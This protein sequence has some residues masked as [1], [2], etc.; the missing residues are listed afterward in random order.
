MTG[1]KNILPG[2]IEKLLAVLVKLYKKENKNDLAEIIV[3]SQLDVVEEVDYDNW[4][5]GTWGHE[6]IFEIPEELYLKFFD[7]RA[8]YEQKITEDINKINTIDDEYVYTTKI[9]ILETDHGNWRKD[10]GLLLDNKILSE[11]NYHEILWQKNMYRMFLSHKVTYKKETAELKKKLNF[12]GIDCFVAHEDIEPTSEWQKEIEKALFSMDC[13][14]ALMTKDFP[15]SNWTDQEVGVA[16]GRQVPIICPRLGKDPY[17]FIGK[18]QGLSAGWD[19]LDIELVKLLL[20]KEPKYVDCYI[21]A[22]KKC[23]SFDNGNKYAKVLPVIEKL[24]N[25]QAMKLK[26]IYEENGE[27][28]GAFGFNGTKSRYYGAGLSYHLKRI[29]GR[30]FDIC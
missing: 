28:Q 3:N 24:T 29:T 26:S 2:K 27:L 7:M 19:T 18:F 20:K 12:W 10:S 22:L 16:F 25:S 23:D 9:A 11:E 4:N 15:E 5:G 8:K 14:V 17:G 21:E 6:V 1:R 30:D 13:L